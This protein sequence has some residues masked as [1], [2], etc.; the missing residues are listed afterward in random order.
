MNRGSL[1][2][3]VY[4]SDISQTMALH[5]TLLVSSESSE[6]IAVHWLSLRL[7]GAM[8]WKLLIIE[9]FSQWKLNK[10]ETE[11]YTGIWGCSWYFW[12]ALS[13]SDLNNFISQFSELTCGRY[14]FLSGFCCWKFK[15][16]AKI[17]F[18][19]K[20]QLRTQCVHTWANSTGYHYYLQLGVP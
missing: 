20:N 11:N 7:F 15:Q 12:K 8:V 17:G 14:W 10:I 13:N 5:A 16:I 3:F 6:W 4:P 9:S 18:G 1:F 19:R 2:C